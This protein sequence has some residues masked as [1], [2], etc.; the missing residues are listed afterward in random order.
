MV[1]LFEVFPDQLKQ[2]VVEARI[3]K[4]KKRSKNKTLNSKRKNS[5]KLY[6]F[7]RIKKLPLESK[8]NVLSALNHFWNVKNVTDPERAQAF[9]KIVKYAK[10]FEICTMG[11]REKYEAYSSNTDSQKSKAKN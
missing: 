7:S 9:K 4:S 6:A 10:Q 2:Q 8:R 1:K 3:E 5:G 11:F